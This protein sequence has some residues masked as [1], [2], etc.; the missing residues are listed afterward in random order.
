MHFAKRKLKCQYATWE[1]GGT[2]LTDGSDQFEPLTPEYPSSG[3]NQH[4]VAVLASPQR[5]V[6]TQGCTPAGLNVSPQKQRA[7]SLVT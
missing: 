7:G 6:S 1:F 3:N 5:A 4:C 2:Y